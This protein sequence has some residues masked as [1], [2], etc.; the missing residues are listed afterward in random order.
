MNMGSRICV[1]SCI[2]VYENGTL[3]VPE[4]A[5]PRPRLQI[6]RDYQGLCKV[7][8]GSLP[9]VAQGTPVPP[10]VLAKRAAMLAESCC[11]SP[12]PD[13]DQDAISDC[14]VI[15]YLVG[16]FLQAPFWR[17]EV[18]HSARLPRVQPPVVSFEIQQNR[19]LG[20]A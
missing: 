10:A 5:H 1:F 9:G 18:R 3:P 8:Q 4:I 14:E 16:A 12:S 17:F 13:P 11:L 6:L 19:K 20:I 2:F 7:L 15:L